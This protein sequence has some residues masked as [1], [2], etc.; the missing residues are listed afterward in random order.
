MNYWETEI[1][2]PITRGLASRLWPWNDVT[3]MWSRI[4][5]KCPMLYFEFTPP[6]TLVKVSILK[7]SNF[8]TCVSTQGLHSE[9]AFQ[10]STRPHVHGRSFDVPMTLALQKSQDQ[11]LFPFVHQQQFAKWNQLL[12]TNQRHR[13]WWVCATFWSYYLSLI[14]W[15]ERMFMCWLQVKQRLKK[16]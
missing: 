16:Q 5:I 2:W 13:Y 7:H 8:I 9:N 6:A 3:L 14:N 10:L 1:E 12:W 11:R 15:S 4:I